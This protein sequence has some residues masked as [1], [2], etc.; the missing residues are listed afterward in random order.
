MLD[1]FFFILHFTYLGGGVRTHPPDYGPDR[2]TSRPNIS[3]RQGYIN[4]REATEE[5]VWCYVTTY[6][7]IAR[8]SIEWACLYPVHP[9]RIFD[10]PQTDADPTSL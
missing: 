3:W 10:V 2:L 6:Q 9:A 5:A 1:L 4:L 8:N 7:G